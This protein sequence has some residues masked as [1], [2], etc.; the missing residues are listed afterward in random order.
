MAETSVTDL[1][2]MQEKKKP[3]SFGT[4]FGRQFC[5]IPTTTQVGDKVTLGGLA[6]MAVYAAGGFFAGHFVGHAIRGSQKNRANADQ[7]AASEIIA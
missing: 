7:S 3:Y 1:Q 4:G 2:A 5:G 6:A